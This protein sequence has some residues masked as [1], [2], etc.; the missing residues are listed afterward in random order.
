MSANSHDADV[1][2]VITSAIPA[3]AGLVSAPPLP[4][5]FNTG[6]YITVHSILNVDQEDM[7]GFNGLSMDIIQINCWSK[8]HEA[9]WHLREQVKAAIRAA[10][11]VFH[12]VNHRGDMK[13][14]DGDRENY[15]LIARFNIWFEV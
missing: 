9:A 10:V 7:S 2:G 13:L 3:M 8:D 12:A 4:V 14:Y 11:G 5:D 1:I 15:Q 6:S